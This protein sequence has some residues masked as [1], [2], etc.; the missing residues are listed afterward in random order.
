MLQNLQEQQARGHL[1]PLEQVARVLQ[2]HDML[3]GWQCDVR[4][5][6]TRAKSEARSNRGD[7]VVSAGTEHLAAH[8]VVLAAAA[9]QFRTLIL[10]GR[11]QRLEARG[12]LGSGV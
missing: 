6:D 5:G 1:C 4:N 9:E 10:D 12:S 7:L 3:L 8:Q 11:Q 2:L